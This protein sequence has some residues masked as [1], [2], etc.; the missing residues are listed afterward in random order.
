MHVCVWVW[1]CVGVGVCVLYERF[2]VA[3]LDGHI[4]EAAIQEES[5]DHRVFPAVT[6][7]H[8]PSKL[9]RSNVRHQGRP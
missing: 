5:Y 8:I 3:D 7:R 9:S 4:E 2:G 6:A 1:V